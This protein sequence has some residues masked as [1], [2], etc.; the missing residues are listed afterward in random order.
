MTRA[1]APFFAVLAVA[2]LAGCEASTTS[3]GEPVPEE[4][5]EAFGVPA[6]DP[7]ESWRV[8]GAA[9]VLLCLDAAPQER[10]EF[11]LVLHGLGEAP[12]DSLTVRIRGGGGIL[13]PTSPTVVAAEPGPT[14]PRHDDAH[15]L[16]L[17]ALEHA[18][19]SARLGAGAPL[20]R[21][22]R[23]PAALP[24]VGSLLTFN[25]QSGSACEEPRPATGEVVTVSER[26]IVVADT[27]NPGGGFSSGDYARF[28]ADFDTLVAPL[29]EEAF[30]TGANFGGHGRTVLF[31]TREVNR[32]SASTPGSVILGFFFA[33][34]LFPRETGGG[35]QGCAGSNETEILY[36]LVPDP[37]GTVGG[38]ARS[39]QFVDNRTLST[40]AHE[41]QHLL[42]ASRRLHDPG[43]RPLEETWLNE[44]L[45]HTAEE[46]LF[47]RASGT[48]P[49]SRLGFD[50][51]S[52]E[53]RIWNAFIRHQE[54]NSQRLRLYMEEP[55]R[56]SPYDSVAHLAT[57][58]A[59]WS[60]LRY[61]LDRREGDDAVTLR[62]LVEGP[63]AG[64][65]NMANALGGRATLESW[66]ADWA[67]SLYTDGRIPEMPARFRNP[68]WNHTSLFANGL[69]QVGG[70]ANHAHPLREVRLA[71]AV[72]RHQM[73]HAGGNAFLRFSTDGPDGAE[74]EFTVG[75]R[76]PPE[77]LHATLVRLR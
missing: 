43:G 67:V 74:L 56:N 73:I 11:L 75:E 68:S 14:D 33:R 24:E 6:L 45:S 48:A 61:A 40:L 15:H 37:Q 39:R 55:M 41:Y 57:R 44:A 29:M 21:P 10:A 53:S 7:G 70:S 60:F 25:T 46:L 71:P 23:I 72:L 16:R 9:A 8:S 64:M 35:F 4:C 50:E 77:H 28:A 76:R 22:V 65:D 38:V 47:F 30:G 66:L 49:G 5:A 17:R 19:L 42:N 2:T 18:A 31:F 58:G 54:T 62:T 1:Q 69:G 63:D 3:P 51:I 27:A 59:G 52:A 26:A 32:L 12:R 13:A 34:D 36:L 20:P